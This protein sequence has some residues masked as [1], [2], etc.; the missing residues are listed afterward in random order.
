MWWQEKLVSGSR[1]LLL[2]CEGIQYHLSRRVT[3]KKKGE[4]FRNWSWFSSVTIGISTGLFEELNIWP[5]LLLVYNVMANLHFL[6]Y[7][8]HG[9]WLSPTTLIRVHFIIWNDH[10]N[11]STSEWFAGSVRAPFIYNLAVAKYRLK[12]IP[13]RLEMLQ[14][15]A[16][17]H[18]ATLTKD[19]C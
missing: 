10:W 2:G 18:K 14:R 17:K 8:G 15:C 16:A 9:S 19:T 4:I 13:Q 11:R 12:I 6:I 7:Y 5:L 1:F 3:E